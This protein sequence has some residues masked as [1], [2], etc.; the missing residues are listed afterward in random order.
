MRAARVS[1]RRC[2]VSAPWGQARTTPARLPAEEPAPRDPDPRPYLQARARRCGLGSAGRRRE[3]PTP[4]APAAP[5]L[6]PASPSDSR[7]SSAPPICA[8]QSALPAPTL[9]RA[10]ANERARYGPPPPGEGGGGA[11]AE[12]GLRGLGGRGPGGGNAEG[13]ERGRGAVG[14]AAQDLHQA[15]GEP[16]GQAWGG[17]PDFKSGAALLVDLT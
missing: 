12:S 5:A 14:E 4:C 11:G 15:G 17:E 7:G 10:A 1:E 16:I 8:G 13:Q 6:C 2:P 9:T 3:G